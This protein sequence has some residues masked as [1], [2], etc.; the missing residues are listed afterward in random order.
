MEAFTHRLLKRIDDRKILNVQ[1]RN[2]AIQ[3]LDTRA[4]EVNKVLTGSSKGFCVQP[5]NNVG[6]EREFH[7]LTEEL[8]LDRS[9]FG[10]YFRMSAGLFYNH[11]PSSEQ[12]EQ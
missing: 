4:N 5:A 11:C 1:A 7:L 8:R 3:T 12:A 2:A 10:K 9:W 6:T